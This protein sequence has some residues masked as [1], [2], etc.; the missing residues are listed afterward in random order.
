MHAK[1]L[2]HR[3]RHNDHASRYDI[4]NQCDRHQRRCSVFG[5]GLDDV[6]VDRQEEGQETVP[7]HGAPGHM[8]AL[9]TVWELLGV[10]LRHDGTPK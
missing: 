8:S 9:S 3:Y 10:N 5:E 4:A 1:V 6:H 2:V 7:E